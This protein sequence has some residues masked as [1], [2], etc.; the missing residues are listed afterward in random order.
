MVK[1]LLTARQPGGGIRTFFRYVYGHPCF[2]DVHLTL[3]APDPKLE[4]FL[5]SFI[6]PQNF[7]FHV[8]KPSNRAVY[9]KTRELLAENSYDLLHSH[10]FTAGAMSELA[11]FGKNVPHLMTA[12][13]V[14]R[15]EQFSGFKGRVKKLL[16]SAT[17]SRMDVI[18]AVTEDAR[19]NLLEHMSLVRSRRVHTIV[20]GVDTN[21]F[22]GGRDQN[23][24]LELGTDPGRKLIGFFGRFMAQKGFRTLVDAIALLRDEGRVNDLP[25]VLT[26]GWG[27][28][29]RE[30]Y[31]YLKDKGLED[32]FRQMP[33]TDQM[34]DMLKSVDMVVMPSRW[35]ACGLLAMEA[36]ATGTP[37][38]GSDCIGLR[39]VLKD[40][41][42]RS[43]PSSDPKALASEIESE[44]RFPSKQDVE[45]YQPTAVS[46]FDVS[47]AAT[48]L[49]DLYSSIL[50]DRQKQRGLHNHSDV[51]SSTD[52]R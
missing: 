44:I 15:S 40:T 51:A 22:S 49:R 12:H 48:A 35:E 33:A 6:S 36:L 17:F 7:T 18:H 3:V 11:R 52:Q 16:L 20:H 4:Q 50:A 45:A 2:S 23:L 9:R 27:G 24:R 14:F 19:L 31:A 30:D 47:K 28:F 13:D 46:R 21:F 5:G 38:I 1:V 37:I 29:I 8:V 41:P 10:G 25:L 39:E 34:P 26:F 42:A 32:Y 43:V